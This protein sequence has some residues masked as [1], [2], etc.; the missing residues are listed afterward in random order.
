MS[1]I[2]NPK[3]KDSGVLCAIPQTGTCPVGCAD[4][5]FQ[6]GRS[7]LEPLNEHLPNMPTPDMAKGMVVRCNDGNDSNV[8]RDLVIASMAQYDDV[9]F[10]TSIPTDL[11]GFPGPVVLT[12]NPAGRTD[13]HIWDLASLRNIMALRLRVNPWNRH[14]AEE[15]C[16][17]YASR[18]IPV[19]MTFLAYYSD[20]IRPGYERYFTYRKRTMNSYHVI[21]REGWEEIVRPFIG[22][23][24]MWT[25]GRDADSFACKHCGNCLKAYRM[26]KSKVETP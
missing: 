22:N 24:C 3:T 12:L 5:F 7:Y 26:A 16:A 25:C 13:T 2:E 20:G 6:G 8:N 23:P 4:C 21:T 15:A 10:N 19:I 11:E 1:Y 9:F 14:L 17:R 18:G